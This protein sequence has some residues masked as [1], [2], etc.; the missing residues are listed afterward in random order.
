[1]PTILLTSGDIGLMRKHKAKNNANIIRSLQLLTVSLFILI[2]SSALANNYSITPFYGYQFGGNIRVAS[3]ELQIDDTDNMGFTV[4][5]PQSSN[6]T[7]QLLYIYQDTSLQYKNNFLGTTTDLFD[8]TIEY[9]HVGGIRETT[10][11]DTTSFVSGSLGATY[12]N[13][14]SGGFSDE[15]LFSMSFGMGILKEI[16]KNLSFRV[17]GRL[18]LPIQTAGGAIFCSGGGCSISMAGGTSIIQGD[19]TAGVEFKF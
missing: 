5:I 1:M 10:S 6:T 18:L 16:R 8:L 4:D 15:T 19:V 17:Q 11:G 9:F 7:I 13:P 14:K 3:G 2:S 12:F